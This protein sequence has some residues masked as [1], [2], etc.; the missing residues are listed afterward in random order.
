MP[1]T[2][3]IRKPRLASFSVVKAAISS[4]PAFSMAAAPTSSG[5]G[6]R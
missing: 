2:M 5:E 3:A 4:R 6:S 1:P